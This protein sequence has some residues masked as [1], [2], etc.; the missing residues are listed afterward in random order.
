MRDAGLPVVTPTPDTPRNLPTPRQ[1]ADQYIVQSGDT[2]GSIA[3]A[4]SVGLEDLMAA[5]GLTD[6][7]TISVGQALVIPVPQAGA[8]GPSFK[9]LPDSELV[10]GPASTLFDV[11]AFIREKGGVLA[12]YT[13]DVDGEILDA[14]QI[15]TLVARN[16]SVNP[17][18][19][20]AVLEHR[21]GWVS[22][23]DIIR[24]S[25]SWVCG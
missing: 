3:H 1:A 4:Y 7:N 15:V 9:I 22:V 16:Y 14:A 8:S 6:A 20:L 25:T 21:S 13:Q 10:Y 18:L 2:L 5:N 24:T 12:A 17:R 11:E 23:S 19:L